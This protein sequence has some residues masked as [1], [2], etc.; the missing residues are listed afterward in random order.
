MNTNGISRRQFLQFGAMT[1]GVVALA[2]CAPSAA[3][4]AAP[5][6]GAGAAAPA[7]APLVV[8]YWT[9]WGNLDPA[10]AKIV[11]TE[12]FKEHRGGAT[13]EYKGSS[14]QEPVVTAV[15]AGT[16][17]DAASNVS[18][19]NLFVRGATIDCGPRSRRSACRTA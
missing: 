6:A 7:A 11:E 17:P 10:I 4:S 14:G 8:Q 18:Y 12:E 1:A 13:L 5:A 3:P 15:A 16:P 19:V 2:A 9:G